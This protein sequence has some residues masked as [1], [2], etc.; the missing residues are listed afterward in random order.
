M[1]LYK[2]GKLISYVKRYG[3]VDLAAKALE[4][5][6]Y[7]KTGQNTSVH[8]ELTQQERELQEHMKFENRPLIS[9]L[10]P[11]YNTESNALRA[12]LDSV[13]AQTYDRWELCI[14]DGG[15]FSIEPVVLEYEQ[16]QI[17][18]TRLQENLGISGN[19]NAA[20]ALA[21]GDYVA[22]LDHDDLLEPDALFEIVAKINE[23]KARMVY[24]DED[25][26]SADLTHCFAPYHKPD[27]NKSLLLSN[28]Y[29]CH[30]CAIDKELVDA[31]GGF[32]E[33][34]DGSQDYDL[35]LRIM[36]Q[37]TAI[38]HVPKILYHWRVGEQ[39]TSDNPFNKIYAYDAGKR[40]LE[41]YLERNSLKG[42][43]T[44][45]KDPGYFRILHEASHQVRAQVL[46]LG[47]HLDE[48]EIESR[49]L[50]DSTHFY[51]SRKKDPISRKNLNRLLGRAE[52]TDA[53]IVVPKRVRRNRYVYNGLARTGNG[54][55][56]TLKGQP[57]WFRGRFNLGI[58]CLTADLVPVREILIKRELLS[59]I[60]QVQ[61]QSIASDSM[62]DRMLHMEYAPEVTIED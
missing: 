34:F 25:K 21:K 20:L 36:E 23:T 51:I 55:T 42:I 45:L 58:T 60:C 35:F 16:S 38:A 56:P 6:Y 19:S 18:Y 26:I 30:F 31:A 8:M 28:N 1:N 5:H 61:E 49:V 4:K 14:A 33:E 13:F 44:S 57:K 53:D 62:E 29:I 10:M 9:I 11:A 43:V 27:F 46:C 24:T 22:L 59:W 15:T 12:T 3:I 40:A 48:H 7:Q 47:E 54:L 17:T 2:T 39:S 50:T 32:H 41:A 37:T 52:F